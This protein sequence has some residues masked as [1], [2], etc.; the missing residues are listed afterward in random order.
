MKCKINLF[1]CEFYKFGHL[2]TL[3][4]A[5]FYYTWNTTFNPDSTFRIQI[6]GDNAKNHTYYICQKSQKMN[7]AIG[8]K[9]CTML[10]F[11]RE[12]KIKITLV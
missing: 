6:Y 5:F 2:L 9:I 3:T 12:K 4:T 8:A 11:P 7:G 10:C 1:L